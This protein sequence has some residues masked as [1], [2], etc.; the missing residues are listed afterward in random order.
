MH[1]HDAL[2]RD[3]ACIGENF[4]Q[5]SYGVCIIM[6]MHIHNYTYM[7]WSGCTYGTALNFNATHVCNMIVHAMITLDHTCMCACA[8][9][10][11]NR[12]W[13]WHTATSPSQDARLPRGPEAREKQAGEE[14]AGRVHCHARIP[15]PQRGSV[16]CWPR[17]SWP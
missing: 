15:L 16:R 10:I 6:Y 17:L 8:G 9:G 2:T 3:Y 11:G 5:R 1:V 14:V 13:L 7:A 4:Q 12:G